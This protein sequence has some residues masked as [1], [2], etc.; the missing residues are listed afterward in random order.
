MNGD[1]IKNS[2]NFLIFGHNYIGDVLM[3]TPAIRA[4]KRKFPES[5]ITAVVSKSASP[6][7]RRNP[8]IWKVV[9]TEKIKGIRGI[10]GILNLFLE[11]KKINLK[12]FGGAKFYTCINFL[13]SFKFAV[14][15]FLLSQ[16][17]FGESRKLNNLFFYNKIKLGKGLH[18]IDK[19]LEFIEPFYITQKYQYRTLVYEVYEED[20]ADAENILKN[21]FKDYNE[22]L[23]IV[24]FSPCS[25][26][27]SKEADPEL[28]SLFADYLNKIGYK[29]VITGSKKDR[30]LSQRIFDKIA[31]K[32]LSADLTGLTDIYIL[33]GLLKVSSLAVCV[34][35]G[36]M[37]MASAI[38]TPLISLFGSTDPAVCGPISDNSY[39][40]DKKIGCCHCFKKDCPKGS[41]NK[42]GVPDCMGF[43]ML[44][45]L[46]EGAKR[47]LKF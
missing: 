39:V 33:G 38:G 21:S 35:N 46:T 45:D 2:K 11:L 20:T 30:E 5:K 29:V 22:N 19:A 9:E 34:D 13:N 25:T 15:G 47:L 26:R 41:F 31:D 43:I 37:H 10:S 14:I 18:N 40:I 7:L 42:K 27:R 28:F 3:L 36:A 17:Q 24:L 23:K 4:L 32:R 44:D 12:E 6:V 1:K 16:K 8:D